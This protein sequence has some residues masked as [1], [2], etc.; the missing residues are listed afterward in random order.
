MASLLHDKVRQT[1]VSTHKLKISLWVAGSDFPNVAVKD[2]AAALP[3][4]QNKG[5]PY[6]IHAELP[7]ELPMADGVRLAHITLVVSYC[8]ITA[9]AHQMHAWTGA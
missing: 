9:C 8:P 6:Y 1:C 2:I 3:A 5:V 7:H 4:I